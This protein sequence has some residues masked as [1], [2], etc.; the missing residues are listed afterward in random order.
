M[1]ETRKV[2]G[3]GACPARILIL[4]ERPGKKEIERGE[5]FVGQTG[6]ELDRR[7]WDCH[8]DR[9]GVFLDNLVKDRILGKD[10]PPTE[11]EIHRDEPD[12]WK[13]LDEVR[14]EIIVTMGLHSTRYF[15]GSDVTLERCHAIPRALKFPYSCGLRHIQCTIFPM[16]HI[17]AGFHNQALQPFI[18]YDWAQFALFLQYGD[19]FLPEPVDAWKGA[20]AYSLATEAEFDLLCDTLTE[21]PALVPAIDTEGLSGDPWGLSISICPGTALVLKKGYHPR[22]WFLELNLRLQGRT[23]ALHNSL[24]D[25]QILRELGITI[26]AFVDTMVLAYL[27]QVEPQGLKPLSYRHSGME[28]ADYLD[29]VAPYAQEIYREYLTKALVKMVELEASQPRQATRKMALSKRIH[30]MLAESVSGRVKDLRKRWEN[31]EPEQMEVIQT[32]AGPFPVAGLKHV[33]D[34]KAVPYSARD[35]DA[36]FRLRPAL[37]PRVTALGLDT[38]CDLDHA[39]LP[40]ID[41]M[42]QVGMMVDPVYL[43]DL[44]LVLDQEMQLLRDRLREVIQRPDY[45]PASGDQI[46]NILFEGFKLQ[47]VK[48]TKSKKRPAVDAKVLEE[49]LIKY[50]DNPPAVDFIQTNQEFTERLKLKGTYVDNLEKFT[51]SDGRIHP[52]LRTTRVVS[53][54]LSSHEP[55]LLAIPVR[56]ALGRLVRG[57]FVAPPG[58][59]LGSWD[60]DQIEMRVLAHES[61]DPSMVAVLSD[62]SRHI[63]KETTYRIYGIPV[64]EVDKNSTEYMMSKNISFGIMYG[65]TAEGLRAQMAQRGQHRTVEECQ[66]MIDAYLNVAYPGV[67]EYMDKCRCDAIRQGFVRTLLGRIR[68]IPGIKSSIQ[69]IRSEAERAAGNHPIQGGASDIV[70]SWMRALWPRINSGLAEPLLQVHDELILEFDEGNFDVVDYLVRE[71]LQEAVEPLH[72]R[73]PISCAGKA[74]ANWGDLK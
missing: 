51:S 18:E 26:T 43:R 52:S 61:Q 8:L 74:A 50:Q 22:L 49:L 53:G 2:Y 62:P 41:R 60:L 28:M 24:H 69:A 30:K 45:N 66:G 64:A 1:E 14:P 63:H 72:L 17:A 4:G 20:E 39:V 54:R 47:P 58:R 15:L 44:G 57:G 34:E 10:A 7:L 32:A 35:A 48:L 71:A 29:V 11:E 33:P 59:Q 70:K 40:M 5:P 65:I 46:A 67:K 31:F 38:I 19:H 23:V 9:C 56:T 36:T 21:R 55:N 25:L 16:Y 27:L 42:Q 13:V 6:R 73:V 68:Y 3:V 12:L 37:V